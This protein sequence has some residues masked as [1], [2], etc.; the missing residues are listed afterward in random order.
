M[1]RQGINL[2]GELVPYMNGWENYASAG[3][4]EILDLCQQLHMIVS[5]HSMEDEH[6]ET[7][8]AA[9]PGEH[10]A[11]MRHIARMKKYGNVYLDLSGTGLFQ[12]GMLSYGVQQ[13]GAERFLF[14]SDYPVCN[15]SMQVAGV[16]YEKIS[17]SAKEQIL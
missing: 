6:M 3:L 16:L 8:F 4:S 10:D 11:Y 9:H 5:L 15:P 7:M 1:H 2:V 13:V 14:G 12:Y 17:D